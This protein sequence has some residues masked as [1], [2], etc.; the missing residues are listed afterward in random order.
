MLKTIESEI[1]KQAAPPALQAEFA[2]HDFE[3][4]RNFCRLTYITSIAIWLLFN[5]IISFKGGQGF[6]ALSLLFIGVMAALT[7]ILGF[8]RNYRHFDVLNVMFV[9]VITLGLRLV[10]FGLPA[11][12]QPIWLALAC[13]SV[14]YNASILPLSRWAFLGVAAITCLTLNPFLM[15]QASV[16]DLRGLLILCFCAFLCSVTIYSFFKLRRVTKIVVKK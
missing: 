15:T 10:T 1:S 11:E 6:T 8:I 13:A 7:T 16:M 2:Q 3:K 9:A 14:L 4:L 5:L 12:T